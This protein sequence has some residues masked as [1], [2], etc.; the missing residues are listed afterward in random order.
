MH[1]LCII[2]GDFNVT[3]FPKEKK[4]GSKVRYPFGERLEDVISSWKLVD[5]KKMKGKYSWNNK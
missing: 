4:G 3:I 5:I 2:T 1:L